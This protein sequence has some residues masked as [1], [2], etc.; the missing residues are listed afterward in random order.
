[1][2]PRSDAIRL[3]PQHI[4]F[5]DR[6]GTKRQDFNLAKG[7]KAKFYR[8]TPEE[9]LWFDIMGA[10][11]E[12]AFY[13]WMRPIFW[14]RY[15]DGEHKLLP[16]FD[17]FIDV[18]GRD[19]PGDDIFV[20]KKDAADWAFVLVSVRKHPIYSIIGWRWASDVQRP[21]YLDPKHR[22]PDEDVLYRIG[23]P[24][25]SPAD[26]IDVLWQREMADDIYAPYPSSST[27]Q[28]QPLTT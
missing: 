10:R 23:P 3:E 8:G 11:A 4:E 26:L 1:M 17:C 22:Q 7:K 6:L 27:T 16:D 19:R 5:A 28:I 20:H 18:K 9:S 2:N 13:L 21:E 14:N 12:C 24:H 15:W 25:R